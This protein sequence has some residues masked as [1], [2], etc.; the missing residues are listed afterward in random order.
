MK[1]KA[2]IVEFCQQGTGACPNCKHFGRCF[3]LDNLQAAM[4]TSCRTKND[5]IAEIVIYRCPE[6][7][8]SI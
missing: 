7:E 2:L 8:G 1:A 4:I 5:N 6:F 3:V